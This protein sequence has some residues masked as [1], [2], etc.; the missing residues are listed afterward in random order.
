MV[1]LFLIKRGCESKS[2]NIFPF[3]KSISLRSFTRMTHFG[4]CPVSAVIDSEMKGSFKN[5]IRDRVT[6]HDNG[7]RDTEYYAMYSSAR[8]AGFPSHLK[9][10]YIDLHGLFRYKTF[11]CFKK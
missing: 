1:N 8:S 9:C 4:I 10:F 6:Q 5:F 2:L 7:Y 11:Y 3:V